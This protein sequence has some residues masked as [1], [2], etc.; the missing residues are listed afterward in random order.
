MDVSLRLTAL[1]TCF[2][3]TLSP[4]GSEE[5]WVTGVPICVKPTMCHLW[6]RQ[7]QTALLK[8]SLGL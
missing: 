6:L 7:K 3:A 8:T 5:A 2:S 1:H 4:D